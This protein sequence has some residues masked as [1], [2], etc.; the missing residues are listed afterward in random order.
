MNTKHDGGCAF[1]RITGIEAPNTI[2]HLDPKFSRVRSS[3][4]MSL[5]DWFAGR[6]ITAVAGSLKA[7]PGVGLEV[8]CEEVARAA[9]MLA[10]AM[11]K[12][13]GE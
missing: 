3:D 13:R 10:D 8:V 7:P 4:G 9:Y 5:R 12:A 1:P 2:G 6:S 11:L